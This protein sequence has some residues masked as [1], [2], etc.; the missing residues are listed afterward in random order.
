[1]RPHDIGPVKGTDMYA[2]DDFGNTLGEAIIGMI[3]TV[4][5]LGSLLYVFL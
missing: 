3:F 1:M 2:S 5:I 4:M